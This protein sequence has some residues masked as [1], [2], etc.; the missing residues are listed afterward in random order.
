M[1]PKGL[2][3]IIAPA[4]VL[5]AGV[6]AL[7]LSLVRV[8]SASA[9]VGRSGVFQIKKYCSPTGDSGA[10]GSYCTITYS[11]LPEIIVPPA[12][13]N[14]PPSPCGSSV[15]YT[16][17]NVS[18]AT[19]EGGSIGLDSTV[20][21][22]VGTMDWAVGRCTLDINANPATGPI[23]L[24]TFSDGVGSLAGFTARVSVSWLGPHVD[25]GN[26]YAW[27]GTYSFNPVPYN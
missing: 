20:V 23:G 25:Q 8:P 19:P 16:E 10:A 11:N 2:I 21:L 27:N 26:G 7:A 15:F 13:L 3:T 1:K 9:Q 14:Q 4:V 24:C 22:Y 5:V 6:A 17:A 12:C 18:P